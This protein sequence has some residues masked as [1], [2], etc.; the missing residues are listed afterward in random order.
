MFMYLFNQHAFSGRCDSPLSYEAIQGENP[1]IIMNFF[2]FTVKNYC[3]GP[4]QMFVVHVSSLREDA[5]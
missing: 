1:H 2:H 3:Q 4:Y 5:F